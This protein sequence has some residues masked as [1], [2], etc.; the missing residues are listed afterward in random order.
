MPVPPFSSGDLSTTHL[1]VPHSVATVPR[2]CPL[3]TYMP[4]TQFPL[5]NLYQPAAYISLA[6]HL[7][8][9]PMAR[10][11]FRKNKNGVFTGANITVSCNV[12]LF[13][14]QVPLRLEMLIQGILCR[15]SHSPAA[16]PLPSRTFLCG[17]SCPFPSLPF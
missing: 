9:H 7:A 8:M 15:Y 1:E 14:D 13:S 4:K 10:L 3:K 6:S 11:R 5:A 17:F 12:P 2:G 16:Q